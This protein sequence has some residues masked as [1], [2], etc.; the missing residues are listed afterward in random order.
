LD[1]NKVRIQF[2]ILKQQVYGRPLVYLDSA[3]STQKNVDVLLAE[4]RL[5]L[6]Y[7][8]NIHRASHF[9]ADKAT[10][11]FEAVRDQVQRFIHARYREEIVFT[12]GTTESINLVAFSFGEAFIREGD[13][14]IVS[15][16]EHHSNI[17]PW[18]MMAARR[19]AKIVMF[20]FND[21]GEFQ[22]DNLEKLITPRT[23]ILT[24]CHVSNVLGTINPVKHIVS[25]AH[26]KGVKVLV[27]G[28][29]AVQHLPVDVQQLD[30]DFYAFSSH[31]MYGPNG[32]GVLYGKKELLTEM[33]PYQGGGEMIAEVSF[34]GTIYNEIPYK[35]EAGTP[36]ITGVAGF[37]AALSY[38]EKIGFPDIMAYEHELM[39]YASEQLIQMEGITIYGNSKEKSGVISFNL[40]G[41]HPYDAGMLLDKMGIAVRTG[42]HCADTV[43]QHYQ[44]H[45]T[46]R[47]SFG[48][49]NTIEEIDI[50]VA[51]LIKIREMLA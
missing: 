8:G 23:R 20:P 12:K 24:L 29:Q 38:L 35:F 34:Q 4:R 42:H 49:Y 30:A 37:G 19:K 14:I 28:A 36:H 45:G 17:V 44:I 41:V 1:I 46:V 48:I 15:E 27:D 39:N 9:M 40:E 21:N 33:P 16:M 7:Y 11:A 32:V 26:S 10:E 43:M 47:I 2:P 25:I 31:K 13:E 6:D 50:F 51:A 22:P 5:T 3:A 18:Q